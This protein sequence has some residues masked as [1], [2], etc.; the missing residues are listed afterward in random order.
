MIQTR[1]ARPGTLRRT[2]REFAES[3]TIHGISYILSPGLPPADRVLWALLTLASLAFAIYSSATSYAEWR[4]NL[5]ITTLKDAAKP[6]TNLPFPAITI[7]TDGLDI[8][9][10]KEEIYKDFKVWKVTEGK[11]NGNQEEDIKTLDEYML[12]KYGIKN[13]DKNIIEMVKAFHSPD[14][15]KTL[16]NGAILGQLAACGPTPRPSRRKRSTGGT[17]PTTVQHLHQQAGHQYYRVE[18]AVGAAMTLDTVTATCAGV[19]MQPVCG[20]KMGD[21]TSPLCVATSFSDQAADSLSEAVC[22]KTP[23]DCG[24]LT[25]TFFYSVN[26]TCPGGAMA[27]TRPC[28]NDQIS[29]QPDML[30]AAC[31]TPAG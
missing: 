30:Y 28:G 7:C 1:P 10:V 14:A 22:G 12:V 25:D 13:S 8:E 29:G 27:A 23:S 3:S 18:V 24:V 9:A 11:T 15:D 21:N 16:T 6:V 31:V 26:A 17:V 20:G 4:S 19:G 2:A 5:T